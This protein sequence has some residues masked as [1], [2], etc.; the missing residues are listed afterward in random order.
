MCQKSHKN[1]QINDKCTRSFNEVF[2]TIF[3]MNSLDSATTIPLP[4]RTYLHS[5]V[6]KTRNIQLPSWNTR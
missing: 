4:A 5:V 2:E 1:N 3:S 6:D